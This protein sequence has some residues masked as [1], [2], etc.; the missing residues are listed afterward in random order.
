[1]AIKGCHARSHSPGATEAALRR[2]SS[3]SVRAAGELAA[4]K[5]IP[6]VLLVVE[7][8]AARRPSRR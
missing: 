3:T 5:K 7:T 6:T 2:E 8:Y 4:A 1:M